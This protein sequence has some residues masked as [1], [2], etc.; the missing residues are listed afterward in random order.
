MSKPEQPV[1]GLPDDPARGLDTN[2]LLRYFVADDPEQHAEAAA[3]IEE[4][5]TPEAPGLVHPVALCEL[6]W[7]LRSAYKVPKP[8]IVAVLRLA[9]SVRTLHILDEPRVRDALALYEAHGADF[10]DCL[11]HAVY[12]TEGTGLSTF[13]QTA[14]R[15]PGAARVGAPI[16]EEPGT[17]TGN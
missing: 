12:Q 13:D 2:V 11:L 9:L 16:A 15:L 4:T 14:A 7:V 3:L 17:S 8:K 6:V 10:A 5:L 1:T